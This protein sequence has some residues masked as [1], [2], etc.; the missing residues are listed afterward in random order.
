MPGSVNVE[1]KDNIIYATYVGEMNMEVVQGA[2]D[3]I[4]DYINKGQSNK[5]LY[6]TL[7]MDNPPMKLALEM[8]S[9]D[10]RIKE[11]VVK[12]ATVVPTATTAFMASIAFVLSKNHKVFHKDLNAAEEWLK[13]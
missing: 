9:F 12:S 2:A 7:Q 6:N 11:K 3:S 5:I 8:Q 4:E 10:K 13:S 1:L